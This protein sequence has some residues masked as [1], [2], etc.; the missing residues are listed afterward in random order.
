MSDPELVV[1]GPSVCLPTRS[2]PSAIGPRAA[3]LCVPVLFLLLGFLSFLEVL[4]V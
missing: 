4:A 2:D 1:V 3:D